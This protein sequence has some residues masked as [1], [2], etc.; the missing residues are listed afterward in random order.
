MEQFCSFAAL[1]PNTVFQAIYCCRTCCRG[2]DDD[3][4]GRLPL[5]VCAACAD[6]CHEDHDV[7]YVGM[8]PCYCDCP[9]MGC[10][11][12]EVSEAEADRLG[13]CQL[14]TYASATAANS[15]F[16][17]SHSG[18]GTETNVDRQYVRDVYRIPMLEDSSI[19]SILTLQAKE[20]VK[21]SRETFWLDDSIVSSQTNLHALSDLEQ[22]AWH[23]Y[24]H[25]LQQYNLQSG[26]RGN[27][28]NGEIKMGAEWWVQVKEV[29]LAPA[30][31]SQQSR[32]VS[33]ANG[34]EAVDLHY[35][36][37]EAI[38]ESFGLGLFPKLSTVT[39]LTDSANAPPTLV[40]SRRYDQGVDDDF[41]N[42]IPEM[43]VCRPCTGKHLVFDGRLLHGAPTHFALRPKG[44]SLFED[45]KC[46]EQQVRVTF[47]V[48]I[49]LSHKPA[50]I[51]VLPSQIRE[52][53]QT[54]SSTAPDKKMG[55]G[56]SAN[57]RFPGFVNVS[58]LAEFKLNDVRQL[59]EALRA[60][61]ELPF[62]GGVATWGGDD[63]DDDDAMVLVTYPPPF[64]DNDT[65]LVRFGPGHEAS[66]HHGGS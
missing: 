44:P 12:E 17:E 52:V 33:Y 28:G 61:I 31:E 48:N 19:A 24:S 37:D 43:L 32:L 49:W 45:T 13:I 16:N 15:A 56:T 8:G 50:G 10:S 6:H 35:D 21:H 54:M 57:N 34:N 40:F 60:R 38:A 41:Y 42:A 26:E 22:L 30:I 58:P 5:C 55:H 63:E 25:N 65:L 2:D 23:I 18:P 53:L 27:D 9:E 46:Q 29:T 3:M 47:L 1:G 39:Y 20:I 62:T 14:K 59:P 51:E 36:K 11:I 66:L 64:D 7:E 4:N